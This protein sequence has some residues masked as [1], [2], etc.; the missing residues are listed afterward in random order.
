[1][2]VA[3]DCLV[4]HGESCTLCRAHVSILVNSKPDITPKA[5]HSRSV[6]SMKS[7]Q[8]FKIIPERDLPICMPVTARTKTGECASP[9]PSPAAEIRG[10]LFAEHASCTPC[11]PL[12][13]R[14]AGESKLY[15]TA[16]RFASES[17]V[18]AA[19]LPRR[20]S[21]VAA[22]TQCRVGIRWNSQTR[23]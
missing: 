13:G 6:F 12:G 9:S 17:Q 1:M 11:P 20:T 2:T 21:K 10:E 4:R 3:S 7:L 14:Y 15:E 5:T 18:S 8:H 19:A 22:G 23:S 16:G